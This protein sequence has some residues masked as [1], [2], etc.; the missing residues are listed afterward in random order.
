MPAHLL[1]FVVGFCLVIA[2]FALPGVVVVFFGLGAW[3]TSLATWLGWLKDPGMQ[4]LFFAVA[5]LVL[6]F[7]LR[8][9]VRDWFMGLQE[10]GTAQQAEDALEGVEVRVVSAIESGGQGKVELRGAQWNA[11]S[12]QAL[13]PGTLA[14]IERRNGLILHVRRA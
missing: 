3:L 12:D 8:R 11:R 10:T 14:I 6:L 7:G 9:W 5:S 1:W 2:E 4:S 13:Q